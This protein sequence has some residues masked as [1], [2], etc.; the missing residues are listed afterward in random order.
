MP[1]PRIVLLA[2]SWTPHPTDELGPDKRKLL[3]YLLKIGA[4]AESPVPIKVVLKKAGLSKKFR[5]EAFQHQILGPLRREREVFVGT[6]NAG[7]FLV[8][9]PEDADTTLGFYTWRIRA[10]LRHAR[11]LRALARRTRLMA[12]Y[13]SRVR[14]NK[15]RAAWHRHVP[16]S[17]G[18]SRPQSQP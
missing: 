3:D 11:N 8:T 18:D 7:I 2:E 6:S 13:K 1:K 4:T 16:R 12:G 17:G 5:R 9:S 15:D 10:E 14:G